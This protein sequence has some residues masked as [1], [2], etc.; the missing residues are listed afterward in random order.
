MESLKGFDENLAG[1]KALA[2][3]IKSRIG[4]NVF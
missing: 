1:A 4:K 2:D 3:V